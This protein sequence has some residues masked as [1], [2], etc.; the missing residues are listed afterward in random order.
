MGTA[1]KPTVAQE[2]CRGRG[3]SPPPGSSPRVHVGERVL[4]R[5]V[6]DHGPGPSTLPPSGR[7][8]GLPEWMMSWRQDHGAGSI[9]LG[10]V[11]HE[12][13]INRLKTQGP[14]TPSFQGSNVLRCSFPAGVLGRVAD[15]LMYKPPQLSRDP[16][17][18]GKEPRPS[19]CAAWSANYSPGAKS[20][21]CL[22]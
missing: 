19:S 9:R 12:V 2:R 4:G 1:E 15:G 8:P 13:L 10:C 21:P 17:R 7:H 18:E 6:A 16:Y 11:S 5:T 14:G 22:C 20:A 3:F